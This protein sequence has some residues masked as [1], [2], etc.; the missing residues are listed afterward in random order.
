MSNG[1]QL[2]DGCASVTPKQSE[3]NGVL[4]RLANQINAL[5]ADISGLGSKL[6][7]VLLPSCEVSGEK[8]CDAPD[9]PSCAITSDLESFTR[10][11]EQMRRHVNDYHDRCAL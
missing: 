7:P 3:V 9:K 4:D 10:R 1:N 5:E 6:A 2:T 11:V 8:G